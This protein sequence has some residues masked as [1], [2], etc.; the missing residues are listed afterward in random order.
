MKTTQTYPL[1]LTPA[2]S[3]AIYKAFKYLIIGSLFIV[4]AFYYPFAIFGFF[5]FLACF[6]ISFLYTRNIRYTVNIQ[7]IKVRTGLFPY[8]A[9]TLELYRVKDY[10]ILQPFFMRIFGLMTLQ[11]FTMD[12]SQ[13]K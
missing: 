7:T 4:A 5:I 13:K 10:T 6:W 11:L 1:I 2:V 8:T 9:N 12:V 3:Y